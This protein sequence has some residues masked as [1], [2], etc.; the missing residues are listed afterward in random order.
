MRN[1][2]RIPLRYSFEDIEKKI[3]ISYKH[4]IAL[5]R[6]QK[7]YLILIGGNSRS[8]KTTLANLISDKLN[9]QNIKNIYISLDSWLIDIDKRKENTLVIE[10]YETKAIINAVESIFNGH[11]IF[12]PIYNPIT[13][14]RISE[15]GNQGLSIDEGVAIIDGVITLAIPELLGKADMSIFVDIEDKLRL[16]R[17]SEFYIQYKGLYPDKAIAIIQDRENEEV[18]FINETKKN[19]DIIFFLKTISLT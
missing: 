2:G 18:P 14:K 12:P 16:Q 19:A 3:V 8:G 5:S 11:V 4:K 15:A 10:R 9:F 7:I 1:T 6:S 17:L 13:R